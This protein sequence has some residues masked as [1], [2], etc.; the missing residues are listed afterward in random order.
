MNTI[1]SVTRD[2]SLLIIAL[3]VSLSFSFRAEAQI[4]QK[5]QTS[6]DKPNL[7]RAKD[8]INPSDLAEIL[9][10]KNNK[11]PVIFN[12]GVVED[13][14]GAKRLGAANKKD[15]LEKLKDNL[16]ILPK[17]TAVVIYCG[18]C[19]FEKCPNIRPAFTLLK[20][21]GFSN[22][23]LLN[24]PVNLQQNWINKG[25]PMLSER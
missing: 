18:C 9:T 2:R 3:F 10:N 16:N 24:I 21:M 5:A 8:L 4:S 1:H 20:D 15:N 12:I 25:Y 11:R 7:W 17:N 23:K 6:L 22:G 19:P 13:I 14:K